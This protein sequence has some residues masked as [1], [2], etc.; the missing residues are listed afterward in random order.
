MLRA[1]GID[2]TSTTLA[3]APAQADLVHLY[4]LGHL[5]HQA[6]A[7]RRRWP[8]ARIALT[9]IFVPWERHNV[10]ATRD[11]SVVVAAAK[12]VVKNRL[13]WRRCRDIVR[14]ADAVFPSS[15]AE[16]AFLSRYYRTP[17]GRF[18][19]V[20]TI[21][22]HVADWPA[23][24]AGRAR[25]EAAQALGLPVDVDMIVICAARIEPVKNQR[26]LVRAVA[27]LPNAAVVLFGAKHKQPYAD[28]VVAEGRRLLG[29][30]FR[31][32]GHR[33][34]AEL[35]AAMALADISALCSVRESAGL[36]NLEAA[37]SGCEVVATRSGASEEYF[38]DLAHLCSPSAADIAATLAEAMRS[39]RQPQLRTHVTERFDWATSTEVIA[40]AYDELRRDTAR[41]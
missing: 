33:S 4:A 20:A 37:A 11:V 24:R 41:S 32:A 12:N 40:R 19:R 30:R 39:P 22:L 5:E 15:E 36:V 14:L 21:G 29:P 3:D 34:Q 8:S 7:A 2:A 10:I 13:L 38:G 16:A 27:S 23:P 25:A 1:L 26:V 6:A 28:R 17:R 31:W 35:R 18:W 9:P